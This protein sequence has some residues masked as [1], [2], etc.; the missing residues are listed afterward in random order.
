MY[1]AAPANR[2]HPGPD[3]PRE[4][5]CAPLSIRGTE[6]ASSNDIANPA[7]DPNQLVRTPWVGGRFDT[8]GGT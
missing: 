6:S 8:H 2:T 3:L 1:D 7:G 5:H 4:C